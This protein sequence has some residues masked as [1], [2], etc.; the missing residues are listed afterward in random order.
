MHFK[1]SPR[2][3]LQKKNELENAGFLPINYRKE[4]KKEIDGA[5]KIFA[6]IMDDVKKTVDKEV[7]KA[8]K[9]YENPLDKFSARVLDTDFDAFRDEY[10]GKMADSKKK[11]NELKNKLK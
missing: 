11:L 2:F 5:Q 9:H 1:K 4:V 6:E 7:K 10:L 3:D 8:K